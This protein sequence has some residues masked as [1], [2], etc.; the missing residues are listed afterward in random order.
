MTKKGFF[1]EVEG[2]PAKITRLERELDNIT[3]RYEKVSVQPWQGI[4]PLVIISIICLR[5]PLVSGLTEFEKDLKETYEVATYVK[6]L[7][8]G[9]KVYVTGE[10]SL[11]WVEIIAKLDSLK[12][13][14]EDYKP[15]DYARLADIVLG[16]QQLDLHV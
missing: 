12:G 2:H 3:I 16:K 13:L 8:S 7:Q 10:S 15:S 5:S 14:S 1:V 4:P 9:Y 6:Q 11:C